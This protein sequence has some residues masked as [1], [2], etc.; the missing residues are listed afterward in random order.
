MLRGQPSLIQHGFNVQGLGPTSCNPK[1]PT[2][3]R[4]YTRKPQDG[5]L[6]DGGYS[7]KPKP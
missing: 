6:K 7:G 2:F 3:F 5:T 1:P 4:T